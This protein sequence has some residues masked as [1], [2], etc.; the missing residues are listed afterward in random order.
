VQGEVG[1]ESMV[2][3][4]GDR[5]CTRDRRV[6]VAAH[7]VPTYVRTVPLVH[8]YVHVY[9]RTYYLVLPWYCVWYHWYHWYPYTCTY[10]GT[11]SSTTYV[12]TYTCTLMV[13][14]QPLASLATMVHV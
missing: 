8:T 7:E 3:G 9:V 2:V 6:R 12:R 5:L 4:P 1:R 10:H 14:Y 11:Y 13:E